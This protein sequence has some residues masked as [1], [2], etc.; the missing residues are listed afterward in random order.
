MLLCV[1]L[2][3]FGQLQSPMVCHGQTPVPGLATRP[4]LTLKKSPLVA[5]R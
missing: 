4:C 5:V 3:G 1:L 2:S